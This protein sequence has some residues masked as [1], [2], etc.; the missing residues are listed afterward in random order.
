MHIE[1]ESLTVQK[2][3]KAATSGWMQTTYTIQM[4]ENTLC[5]GGKVMCFSVLLLFSGGERL[6]SLLRLVLLAKTFL[7][8]EEAEC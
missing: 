4:L 6:M 2:T 7:D 5:V 3:H 8:P 1:R